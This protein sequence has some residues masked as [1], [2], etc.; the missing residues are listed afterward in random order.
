MLIHTHV[1]PSILEGQAEPFSFRLVIL[2]TQTGGKH[3][4][5]FRKAKGRGSIDAR[6]GV[7]DMLMEGLGWVGRVGWERE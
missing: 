3:G 2:A 6:Q 7:R 5:G 4:A 1:F